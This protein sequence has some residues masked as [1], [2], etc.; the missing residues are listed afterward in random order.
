[1]ISQAGYG[2]TRVSGVPTLHSLSSRCHHRR[3]PAR[4]RAA[5]LQHDVQVLHGLLVEAEAAC[6]GGGAVVGEGLSAELGAEDVQ[7]AAAHPAPFAV[8]AEVVVVGPHLAQ[9]SLE[10][11]RGLG[12]VSRAEAHPRP[13]FPRRRYVALPGRQAPF[14]RGW[15]R[16]LL[17]LVH[18][19][20][21]GL[22]AGS[23]FGHAATRREQPQTPIPAPQRGAQPR[24]PQR[25]GAPR[26]AVSDATPRSQS[27]RAAAARPRPHSLAPPEAPR[28]NGVTP[29]PAR[30]ARR[31]TLVGSSSCGD[32]S[33]S[34]L[35]SLT[36]K[37]EAVEKGPEIPTEQDFLNPK[38]VVL[39]PQL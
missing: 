15:S 30:A 13:Q 27:P 34:H 36:P 8:G 33:P 14:L 31:G 20:D 19:P 6:A 18:L 5:H 23:R 22:E 16:R 32:P 25:A 26:G 9:P 24:S 11:I 7:E 37:K 2:L 21:F 38:F 12:E 17:L 1:M 4:S 3:F 29:Y 10:V 39:L 35:S 28:G